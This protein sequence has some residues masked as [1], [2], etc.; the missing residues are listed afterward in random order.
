[1]M[2]PRQRLAILLVHPNRWVRPSALLCTYRCRLT[3]IALIDSDMASDPIR[4][5][6]IHNST[7]STFGQRVS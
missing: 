3:R 2:R 6:Y 4:L 7:L 5:T 1:M